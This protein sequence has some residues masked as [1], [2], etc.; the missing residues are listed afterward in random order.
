MGAI[1]GAAVSFSW[2]A[3]EASSSF[4]RRT[5]T[6]ASLRRTSSERQQAWARRWVC[7]MDNMTLLIL[8]KPWNHLWQGKIAAL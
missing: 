4:T 2:R 6:D 5:S 8:Y 1:R 7:Y 3:A